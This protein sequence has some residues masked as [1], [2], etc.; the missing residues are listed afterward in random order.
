[1][2]KGH[3]LERE[4][5]EQLEANAQ[6]QWE[7]FS[8]DAV[9]RVQECFEKKG[10]LVDLI[11]TLDIEYDKVDSLSNEQINEIVLAGILK[12][13]DLQEQI[14][15]QIDGELLQ[16]YLVASGYIFNKA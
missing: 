11:N 15:E 9:E 8:P 14:I 13:E 12:S 10:D 7:A 2:C 16:N 6:L 1:M 5:E 3:T 4:K